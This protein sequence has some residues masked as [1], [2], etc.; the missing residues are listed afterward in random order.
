MVRRR[1]ARSVR[2]GLVFLLS[3]ALHPALAHAQSRWLPRAQLDNDAY[4][5]WLQP[6][7]RPDEEYT[8][9][10]RLSLES[11]SAPWWGAHLSKGRAGCATETVD[12]VPC[13][14][15][16]ATL[17]QE[18]YTP[19]LDRAP[20]ARGWESERPYFAWLYLRGDARVITPRTLRTTS[21][22]LGVTG[23]PAGG[24]LAQRTAHAINHRYTRLAV[25]WETQIGFEPGIV[26]T[27]RRSVRTALGSTTGPGADFVPFAS[28]SLGNVLTDA[29]LG[30]TV[31]IGWNLSHP[32]DTRGWKGRRSI[33]GW[34][35]LGGQAEYVARNIS[36]DGNTLSRDRHVDRTPGVTQYDVGFGLRF[37]R[38][39]MSYHAVTRS[40]EYTTGP[41]HHSFGSMIAA[42][43]VLP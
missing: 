24:Q 38:L 32:W 16:T 18:L 27:E 37:F 33:E 2:W 23:P 4:N 7:L 9:G 43:D 29:E 12:S 14:A 13:L 21:L 36:L 26:V 41:L 22:S 40:R 15:T 20:Y 34:V 19:R 35:S 17:G 5:F 25:G 11:G 30:G 42:I 28:A 31:R 8:N 1:R 10:V 3:S 39:D 6:G